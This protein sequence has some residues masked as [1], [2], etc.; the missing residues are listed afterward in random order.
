MSRGNGQT[1]ANQPGSHLSKKRDVI[2]VALLEDAFTSCGE[3]LNQCTPGR[4]VP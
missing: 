4:N 3:L 1:V 2:V